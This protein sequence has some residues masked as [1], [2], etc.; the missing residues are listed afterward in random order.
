M[1]TREKEIKDL[2]HDIHALE[3]THKADQTLT[4][5]QELAALRGKLATLLHGR[6]QRQLQRSKTYFYVSSDKCVRL[7]A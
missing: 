6:Y 4:S 1:R 7:L 3:T 5:F 2:V